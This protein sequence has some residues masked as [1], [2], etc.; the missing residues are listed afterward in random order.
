MPELDVHAGMLPTESS[1]YAGQVHRAQALDGADGQPAA[2]QALHRRHRVLGRGDVGQRPA[3]LH[4]QGP[5]GLG[6]LHLPGA[7]QEQG[8]AE[9]PFERAD[10]RG[11]AGL[12]HVHAL[13]GPGEVALLGDRDEVFEL[14]QFHD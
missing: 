6:Q 13:R 5:A 2:Q 4:Q 9:L 11:Q 12:G 8:G 1:Q 3:G 7:A 14:A 10:G